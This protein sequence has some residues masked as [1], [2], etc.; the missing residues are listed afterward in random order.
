MRNL[1][2]KNWYSR[3]TPR[4]LTLVELLVVVG[5]VSVLA[6]VVLPS[7]K[8]VLT[9]R[10]S[11]QAAILVRNFMESARARAIG[12]NRSVAVVLERL[13]SRA[14]WNPAASN[15]IGQPGAYVSETAS[16]LIVS[17]DTNWAPYN[18][19]IR[20]S[21]AEEPLPLTEAMLP[22]AVQIIAREPRD[23]QNPTIPNPG[24]YWGQDQ[25]LDDD[26]RD[27][28]G[29]IVGP[30]EVRIFQVT[31]PAGTDLPRLLGEYLVNGSE[32]SFGNS[33]RRFTIVSPRDPSRHREH[34]DAVGGSIWFSVMNE[35]G[36]E[37]RGERA[38]EPYEEINKGVPTQSFKI[39]GRP[40]PVYSE[41]V[42]L[43]RGICIDLS[44]SGFTGSRSGSLS[45]P[46]SQRTV[47]D[48]P[49]D[50]AS[51]KSLS[52]YR[53]RFASDWIGNS[54]TPL[55]PEQLR[56]VYIVFS[57]EGTLSHVWANDRNTTGGST[58]YA[59]NLVRIDAVND[60]F[61]HIGKIDKVSMTVD[62]NAM[63]RNR[64]GFEAA[65]GSGTPQNLTDLNSYV[66]RLSPKSGSITA[67]PVVGI[68]T[69]IGILGLDASQLTFGDLVELS[70]RGTYNSNVTAQ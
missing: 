5:V 46:P 36:F 69:Q 25:L 3:K 28:F 20:M 29:N 67:A 2:V 12:K 44:L 49:I 62:P 50:I 17:P 66:V 27:Q 15:P 38:L 6:A 63:A 37:G 57:P 8:T 14:Q 68:D 21:L 58:S 48:P 61:L 54:F 41:V 65:V 33:K 53:L 42:Q 60:I 9:D 13:S 7:V 59:G 70:R 10:K 47:I 40:K 23:Q 19:C 34:F 31:A 51:M 43:P 4:G 32:I 52:D 1:F 22:T 18:A 24:G 16:G 35:K 56:P 45:L 55:T 26:Q 30:E 64:L 11:S 39:Y